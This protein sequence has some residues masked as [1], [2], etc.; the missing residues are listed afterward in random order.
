MSLKSSPERYG[1]VAIAI[2]WV[3]AIAILGLLLSGFQAAGMEDDAAKAGL[4]RIHA[5]LGISVLV[6]TLLRIAWW[7]FVD[8]RPADPAGTPRWQ[9]RTA[10][11]VHG[12]LYAVILVMAASGIGM[13]AL[14]GA[15]AILAGGAALPL[16]DFTLYPP[17]IPHG[18]G[19]RL[20]LALVVLHV[21]AALHHQFVRRDRLLARMGLGR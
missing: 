14:S 7:V 17:R 4:L 13:L 6:L 5:A 12:L 15:G 21:G 9:V 2:H 10:H 11:V 20:L 19:S 16:P 18:I 1:T 3:T 8:R